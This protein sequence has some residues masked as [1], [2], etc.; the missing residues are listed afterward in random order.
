MKPAS[1]PRAGVETGARRVSRFAPSTTGPAHAGTLLAALLCWLDARSSGA[2]LLLRLE[3]L[4]PQRCRPNFAEAM[5][6]D[7]AWLGLDFDEV[8]VQSDFAAR[9]ERALDVLEQADVLYPCS[10][11]RR[12]LREVAE[13]A[14]GGGFRY[15]GTCRERALPK[16][17]RR[18]VSGE[19]LRVRL[20]SAERVVLRDESGDDLSQ[21][22]ERTFGDPVV[23]R[24][25]GAVGYGLASLVDDIAAGVNRVVRGRDLSAW[26]ATQVLLLRM[27]GAKAPAYRHHLLLL[28]ARGGK[29]AKFHG[30]ASAAELRTGMNARELCG[31]LACA[32]GLLPEPRPVTPQELL[33]DFSWERA[34][35]ENRLAHWNGRTL[36]IEAA[37]RARAFSAD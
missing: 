24:R 15:P 6:R 25:D 21:N 9:H 3:N 32:A 33:A 29:L 4:D 37:P 14:P 19:A 22:P 11:S 10:C 2:R 13:P 27:L 1:P 18:F 17:G 7:L 28:E 26:T 34:Q 20:P 5:P 23:R 12:T 31:V 35:R 16:G 8:C 30:A 36:R